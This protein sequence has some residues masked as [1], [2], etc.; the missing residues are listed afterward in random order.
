MKTVREGLF[1]FFYC[2]VCFSDLMSVFQGESGK[3]KSSR[4]PTG[5]GESSER[6]GEERAGGE[7]EGT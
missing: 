4:F 3:R 6:E 5:A 7:E 1:L 2:R